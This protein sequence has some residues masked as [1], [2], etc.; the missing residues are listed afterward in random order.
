MMKIIESYHKLM[1]THPI[2]YLLLCFICA[3]V[4]FNII[5]YFLSGIMFSC[6]I[7]L[8]FALIFIRVTILWIQLG[9]IEDK[10]NVIYKLN[11][12]KRLK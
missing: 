3:V 6:A 2:I 7:A 5:D 9:V 10:L 1:T 11:K 4:C 12:W 8:I